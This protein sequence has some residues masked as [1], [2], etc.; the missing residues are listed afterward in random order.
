MSNLYFRFEQYARDTFVEY[1]RRAFRYGGPWENRELEVVSVSGS[2]GDLVYEAFFEEAE[3]YP[4]VT[5]STGQGQ[6][7]PM[8]FNNQIEDLYDVRYPMG[9]RSL[10]LLEFST[11]APV[12]FRLPQAFSGSISGLDLDLMWSDGQN[13]DDIG[14]EIYSAYGTANEVLRASGSIQSTDVQTPTAFFAGVYPAVPINAGEEYWA[15]LTPQSGS[16][17]KIAVDPT[18]NDVYWP[19]A[20][21]GTVLSGSIHGG[22]RVAPQMRMGG[23]H[24]CTVVVRCS[25]KNSMERAQNLA[26][27]TEL[28]TRLGQHAVLN[29]LSANPTRMD[30]SRL[31]VGGVPYLTSRGL[32]VKSVSKTALENR[33]RGD[34]D[35]VFTAGVAIDVRTEWSLDFDEQNILDIDVLGDPTAYQ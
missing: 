33:R 14:I 17:Y 3:H 18:A 1:L 16:I 25:A 26:D 29:R 13:V 11:S 28:Y 31:Y 32:T 6:N 23:A 22:L 5:V 7:V 19:S 20:P 8:A 35:T 9:T 27:L 4:V 2:V 21:V 12:A 15:V 34:N 24:E 10:E 30:L